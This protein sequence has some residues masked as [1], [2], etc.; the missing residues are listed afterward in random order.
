[1]TATTLNTPAS[2][3]SRVKY[4]RVPFYLTNMVP[5]TT[6]TAAINGNNIGAWCKPD[7]K[8]LWAPLTSDATGK[9]RLTYMLSIPYN[10]TYLTN[11]SINAGLLS[12]STMITFTSPTGDVSYSYLPITLKSN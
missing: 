6:Y 12:K 8:A 1:M 10:T 2:I 9:L 5:N 4:F 11:P 3:V 7:G